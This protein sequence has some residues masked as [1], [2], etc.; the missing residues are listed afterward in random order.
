MKM[1]APIILLSTLPFSVLAEENVTAEKYKGFY[2]GVE[3]MSTDY[4]YKDDTVS[5]DLSRETGY[6]L[7]VGYL[8]PVNDNFYLAGELSYADFGTSNVQASEFFKDNSLSGSIEF[9]TTAFI[10]NLKPTYYF[11]HSDFSLAGVIGFGSYNTFLNLRN[12]PRFIFAEET[13]SAFS[14]GLEANYGLTENVSLTASYMTT[15]IEY[16]GNTDV[17]LD[18]ISFG[19]NYHF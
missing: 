7:N 2:A 8:Y 18:A 13:E 19:L 15:S 14:Y 12:E 11:G 10:F 9:Y 16:V 5:S 3:L 17:D 4:A 1:F 6:A